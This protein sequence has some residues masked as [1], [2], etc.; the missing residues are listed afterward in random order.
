VTSFKRFGVGSSALVEVE[1]PAHAVDVGR[2]A[3]RVHI[4]C[5]R[6]R[7]RSEAAVALAQRLLLKS[8]AVEPPV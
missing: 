8:A 3:E 2:A 4:S 7:S 6:R 5:S 1:V